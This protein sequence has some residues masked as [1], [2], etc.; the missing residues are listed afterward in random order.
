MLLT[1]YIK[2]LVTDNLIYSR[3]SVYIYARNFTLISPW[4]RTNAR[5]GKNTVHQSQN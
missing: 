5:N 3:E 1:T 4:S 2:K